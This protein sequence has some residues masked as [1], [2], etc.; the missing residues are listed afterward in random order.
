[1][2]IGHIVSAVDT[3]FLVCKLVLVMKIAKIL[4]TSRQI[5]INQKRKS[6]GDIANA[7]YLLYVSNI[8]CYN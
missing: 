1:M 5:A 3:L 2:T 7:Q 6:P 4:L 8:A